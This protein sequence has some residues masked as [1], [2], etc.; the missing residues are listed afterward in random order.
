MTTILTLCSASYLA[1]AK[2]LAQ[3]VREHMPTC[4][5]VIGLVDNLPGDFDASYLESFELL[6]V[7]QLGLPELAGMRARYDIVELICAMK[8]FFVEH[9]YRRDRRVDTVLYLD[10][11]MLVLSSLAPLADRLREHDLMLTPHSCT[12]SGHGP[13]NVH[14]ERAM[15]RTGVFNLGFLGTRRTEHTSAFLQWWQKRLVEYCYARF[16][17]GLFVDQLWAV[18]APAYVPRVLVE[19]DPGC[20]MAYWNLFERRLSGLDGRYVVNGTHPLLFYHFSHYN[21]DVPDA[22]TTRPEQPVPM[23][24]ERPDLVPL[25]QQYQDRLVRNDYRGVR[26]FKSQFAAPPDALTVRSGVGSS[27]K[28]A[29]ARVI[30]AGLR[31]MPGVARRTLARAAELVVAGAS[32]NR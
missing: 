31:M 26:R 7:E 20:N 22:I 27:S 18:L 30:K 2:T 5:I 29:A 14:Y 25:F 11:D 9:L 16:R 3:S 15:L 19:R 10:A 1:H 8:P 28:A 17:D 12:M 32:D 24:A 21:P 6:P 13:V 4:S 23:L